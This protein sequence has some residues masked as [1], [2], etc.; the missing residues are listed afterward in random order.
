MEESL[1]QYDPKKMHLDSIMN[2]YGSDLVKLAYSYV[3]DF[4]IAEDL[5]Q[6]AFVS[7]YNHLDNFRGEASPKTILY[8]I[9]INKCKDYFKSWHYRK[10]RISDLFG[11]LKEDKTQTPEY[12]ILVKERKRTIADMVLNLP[13]KYREVVY[14]Y[15]YEELGLKDISNTL[16]VNLSTVKTRLSKGKE[17][18]RV[19]FEEGSVGND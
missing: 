8:R 5:V 12:V 7:Y 14:L 19:H 2:Q 11:R 3:K 10:V 1:K 16:D 4:Q 13:L 9:T 18:L 15:Y 6:E 17:L